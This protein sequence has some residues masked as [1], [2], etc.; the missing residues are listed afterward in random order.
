MVDR[1]W[2]WRARVG[3]RGEE[4]RGGVAP[5]GVRVSYQRGTHALFLMSEVPMRCILGAKYPC[6]VPYQRDIPAVFL[7]SEVPLHRGGVA[8]PA[9]QKS[10]AVPRR[11]RI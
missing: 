6:S 10:G 9:S 2:Y 4:R 5:T 3:Q 8:H 11:A 1:G 7:I